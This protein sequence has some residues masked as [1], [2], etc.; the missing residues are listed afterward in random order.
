MRTA[1]NDVNVD[2]LGAEGGEERLRSVVVRLFGLG[3]EEVF[4]TVVG[5][6]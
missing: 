5:F 6:L 1:N 2:V 4:R 3:L